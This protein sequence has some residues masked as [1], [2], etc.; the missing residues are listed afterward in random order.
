MNQFDSRKIER[1]RCTCQ[2]DLT[3]SLPNSRHKR[4][5]FLLI[6]N[7]NVRLHFHE[8]VKDYILGSLVSNCQH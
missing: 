8:E 4:V 2:A 1:K 5:K 7:K 6:L 3:S